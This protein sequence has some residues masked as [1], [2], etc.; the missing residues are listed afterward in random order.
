M[1]TNGR[2]LFVLTTQR[3]GELVRYDATSHSFVPYLGGI[4]ATFLD[5]SKDGQWVAYGAYPQGTLWRSRLDGTEALQLTF[6]PMSI[7]YPRW[8]PEGSKIAFTGVLP[9]K[10]PEVFTVSSEGGGPPE[11]I[12]TA[13]GEVGQVDA[14][15]SPDG[16]F[17]T[18]AGAPPPVKTAS[19]TNAVHILDL[20]THKVS[21]LPGSQGFFGTYWS[22][23]GRYLS[24]AP[25]G[26]E[27]VAVY[28][29]RAEKVQFLT[30][31]RA[32]WRAWSHDGQY[33]Y[34]LGVSPTPGARSPGPPGS[35][36]RVHVPDG[37][38]EE[39][40]SPKDFRAAP[41][42]G[43]WMGLAPDDSILLVRDGSTSDIYALDWVAP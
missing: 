29:L 4:S 20:R 16:N 3:R 9:G 18:F 26:F 15:W 22:S 19:P 6:P 36:A 17:L 43:S 38:L 23:D 39:V 28:E 14:D 11:Q 27:G 2:K 1:G 37:K 12:A 32:G 13:P 40:A 34:F 30:R 5:F 10:P 24:L 42:Y 35:I 8:S 7:L 41:G 25:V 31:V 33:I 21:T